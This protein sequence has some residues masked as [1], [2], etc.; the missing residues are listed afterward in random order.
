MKIAVT[1][2]SGFLGRHV[3]T[4]L[5]QRGITPV[6]ATRNP[7]ALASLL[8]H[9]SLVH[10]NLHSPP[11]DPFA[12]LGHPDGLIHL[13]WDSLSN[14]HALSHL[15]VELPVHMRF[16]NS[17][18]AAGLRTLAVTGTSLEYGTTSGLKSESMCADPSTAYAVAKDTL[19]RHLQLLQ[20]THPFQLTWHRLFYLYGPGQSPQSLLPQ[21]LGAIASGATTFNMS[22]GEQIRDFHPVA[23]AAGEIVSL[24]LKQQPF[25]IVNGCS[26]KPISVRSFI[27][28]HLAENHLS[29]QLGLGHYPYP[30]YEPFAFWGDTSYL[31][32]CLAS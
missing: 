5:L 11:P 27:E 2:G 25:G 19:R 20:Q 10:L 22:G 8:P 15:E 29:I 1:G 30:T 3:I 16:L 4:A 7:A 31:R 24:A 13:A 18:V 28:R 32:H 6:V 23:T 12:A 9:A 14:Y 26:G 17:L 21:L